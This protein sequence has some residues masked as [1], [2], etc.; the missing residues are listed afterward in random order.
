[1]GNCL[2]LTPKSLL[3]GYSLILPAFTESMTFCNPSRIRCKVPLCGFSSFMK[4]CCNAA[5]LK[6]QNGEPLVLTRVKGVEEGLDREFVQPIVDFFV[7]PLG[8]LKKTRPLEIKL[9]YLDVIDHVQYTYIACKFGLPEKR[10]KISQSLEKV[11]GKHTG[12]G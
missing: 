12:Y 10:F 2:D 11:I 8:L 9:N 3:S 6:I 5:D 7:L 1:M 4:T